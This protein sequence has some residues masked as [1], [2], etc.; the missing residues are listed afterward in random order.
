MEAGAESDPFQLLN[1]NILQ[2][3]EITVDTVYSASK[4]SQK[5]TDAPASV[6]VVTQD[7]FQRFGYRTLSDVVRGV[8]GFD[9]TYDRNYSYTGVR[10]FSGLGDYGSRNLLLIDGHRMNEPIYDTTAFG[11]DELLDLDLVDRV[12]FVRGPSSAVYGSNAFFGVINVI[13]RRGRDIHGV[14]AAVMDGSLGTY[15][16]R[17]TIG[18]Q[19]ST[20]FEYLFSVS[21]YSSEGQKSLYYKEFDSP[22]TNHGLAMN[23]DGDQYWS[24]MGKVSYGDFTI[25]GGYVSRKK[26][27]PTASFES[28]FNTP[29]NTVDSRGYMELRYAHETESGWSLSGRAHFDSYDYATSSYYERATGRALNNDADRARWWG[30]EMGVSRRFF[31]SLRV[32]MGTEVRQGSDI[33]LRNYDLSPYVSYLNTKSDLLVFGTYLD[34]EWKITKELALSAGLCWDHYDSF[35]DKADPRMAFVWKPLEDTT[36]KLLYGQAFHAANIYQLAYNSPTQPANPNLQPET[37]NSYEAV[38]EQYFGRHWRASTSV[39]RNEIEGIINSQ[40]LSNGL[41]VYN[42]S[43]DATVMGA[44]AEIEGKWENGLLLRGSYTHQ[45]ASNKQTNSWLV[46]SPRNTIKAQV[47]VPLWKNRVFGG[48]ELLY[49]S[50]RMT[51]HNHETPAVWLLNFT[52]F[53]RAIA[54]G[55][56]ASASIYNLLGQHYTYP[57]GVEHLQDSIAQDGR[58]FQVKLTYHF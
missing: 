26:D 18:D 58:T 50:E 53:S 30:A 12:E 25:Q 20:G 44:E 29:N 49:G 41:L 33:S 7:Q 45:D 6:S 14:E 10:G 24:T 32:A 17:L 19:L 51:L 52:L 54:P 2:L 31:D 35:G 9:V 4:F 15:S 47:A 46:N 36:V 57:G 3:A 37:V 55:L 48:L 28:V 16:G 42:N 13:S 39:F 38:V 21:T 1:L 5:V 40:S 11:T 8:R 22:K 56:D 43:C 23:L 34:S 27:V